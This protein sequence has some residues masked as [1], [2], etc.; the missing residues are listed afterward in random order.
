MN[1]TGQDWYLEANIRGIGF[2]GPSIHM[3]KARTT[4]K[5]PI[6]FCPQV[7]GRIEVTNVR[8]PTGFGYLKWLCNAVVV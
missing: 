8:V 3:V 7:E 1:P 5:Y 2:V 4:G 6:I